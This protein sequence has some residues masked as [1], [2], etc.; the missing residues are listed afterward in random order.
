MPPDPD[1]LLAQQIQQL[2]REYLHDSSKRVDELRQLS[3]QLAQDPRA[4]FADLHQ[5][6]HR[7]AGSGGS[8]GYP[9]VTARSREGEYLIVRLEST[10][11]GPTPAD[12]AAINQIIDR[13]A[14]AFAAAKQTLSSEGA[15]EG[16]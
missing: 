11:A 5:A 7:L 14:D 13:V 12:L 15:S 2:R 6:F 3:A 4:P 9:D 1:D 10:G 16:S 8:Y